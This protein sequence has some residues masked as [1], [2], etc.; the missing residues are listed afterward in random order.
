[1]V[2]FWF[3]IVEGVKEVLFVEGQEVRGEKVGVDAATAAAVENV[4]VDEVV[5]VI[6]VVG[7]IVRTPDIDD[8]KVEEEE[9]AE[10]DNLLER[11]KESV[12]K[13]NHSS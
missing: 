2:V 4:V 13:T 9:V 8:A 6:M 12:S 1:V 11:K 5:R 7:V 10:E 3:V